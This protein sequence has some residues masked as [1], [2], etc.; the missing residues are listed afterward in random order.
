[1]MTELCENG[2][3]D[4]CLYVMQLFVPISFA[5]TVPSLS[6]SKHAL[7]YIAPNLPTGAFCPFHGELV[8][9]VPEIHVYLRHIS[10]V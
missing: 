4:D 6:N 3:V 8:H 7:I 5:S 10:G 2:N 1:M 9:H